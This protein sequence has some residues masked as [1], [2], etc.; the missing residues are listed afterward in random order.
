MY[1]KIF[2]TLIMYTN[3]AQCVYFITDTHLMRV[4]INALHIML[5]H[6]RRNIQVPAVLF[7]Q[8]IVSQ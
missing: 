2:S 5:S 4:N 7:K 6:K 8:F 3:I 1:M